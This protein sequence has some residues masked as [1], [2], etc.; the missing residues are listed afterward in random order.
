VINEVKIEAR[1]RGGYKWFAGLSPDLR[2]FANKKPG[3]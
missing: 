1:Y 3:I 2:F